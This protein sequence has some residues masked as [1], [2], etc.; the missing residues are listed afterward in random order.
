MAIAADTDMILL[1]SSHTVLTNMFRFALRTF[2]LLCFQL[3]YFNSLI[4]PSFMQRPEFNRL[5]DNSDNQI[6]RIDKLESQSKTISKPLGRYVSEG[7]EHLRNLR[8]SRLFANESIQ[9]SMA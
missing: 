7:C 9:E 3:P 4:H 2:H 8:M 5:L 6:K 1:S